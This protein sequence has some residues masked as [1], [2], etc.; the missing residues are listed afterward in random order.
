MSDDFTG[1]QDAAVVAK[2]LLGGTFCIS[3]IAAKTPFDQ[4]SVRSLIEDVGAYMRVT[5]KTALS[6]DGCSTVAV[7][8]GLI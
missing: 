6:C 4:A 2:I 1:A 3:C 8:Y 5:R 7:A